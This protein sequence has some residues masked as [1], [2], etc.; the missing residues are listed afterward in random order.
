MKF[1]V[2]N[3]LHTRRLIYKVDNRTYKHLTRCSQVPPLPPITID[4]HFHGWLPASCNK[5]HFPHHL[6][7]HHALKCKLNLLWESIRNPC[8]LSFHALKCISIGYWEWKCQGVS[9]AITWKHHTNRCHRVGVIFIHQPQ[10]SYIAGRVFTRVFT[11][12]LSH[13]GNSH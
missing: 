2:F 13:Q 6:M 1:T 12:S 4:L 7:Y 11:K 9:K 10:V 3:P 8:P 5:D